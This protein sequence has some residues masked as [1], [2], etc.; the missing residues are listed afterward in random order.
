VLN[1]RLLK[2]IGRSGATVVVVVATS[3][4]FLLW[5]SDW[6]S[7]YMF[8]VLRHRDS[9]TSD[10]HWKRSVAIHASATP[11]PWP[12]SLD[13]LATAQAFDVADF[14]GLSR[15]LQSSGALALVI[16]QH[17]V[18]RCEWYGNSG[19]ADKPAAAFSISKSVLALLLSRAVADDSIP[20]LDEPV[21]DYV[22]RLGERDPRFR[23]VTLADLLD[24]R[25][26]IAFSEHVDFP[27]VDQDAPAVYYASDLA[28]TVVERPHV[29]S[30]PGPFVYNDYA[31]NIAGI[32]LERATGQTLA[33]LTQKLWT[34][35]GAQDAALWSTDDLGFPYHESGFV[36]TA[37]DLAR[38]GSLLLTH[39][40]IEGRQVAPQAFIDRS[41]DPI[42]HA[43]ATTFNG[44]NVGYRN[45][46][47]VL[48]HPG[49][50]AADLVAMGDHGQVMLVSPATDS[51]IVRMG[52]DGHPAMN[53][54]IAQQLQQVALALT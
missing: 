18:I 20:S 43:T 54:T 33:D 27:W 30:A 2:I 9:G 29:E 11:K 3:L 23:A 6:D 28:H 42:G 1:R 5:K 12:T 39:G 10:F 34:E 24:M 48:A 51:V 15:A 40:S 14:E 13:C 36:A 7:R 45:G 38:V 44:I 35:L 46:W 31:P 50:S 22:S 52:T 47:W 37:R 17:G 21:T 8:R 41:L 4:A 53:I 16:I 32:A 25:S 19:A 26:G 49:S